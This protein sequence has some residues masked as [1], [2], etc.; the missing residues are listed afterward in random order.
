MHSEKFLLSSDAP[1]MQAP[2]RMGA[3]ESTSQVAIQNAKRRRVTTW[4]AISTVLAIAVGIAVYSNRQ[5][6]TERKISASYLA[7]EQVKS[8]ELEKFQEAMKKEGASPDLLPDHTESTQKFKEFALKNM[9]AALGWQAAFQAASEYL[10]K[11]QPDQAKE[12]LEPLV[13]Q[14]LDNNMLQAKIRRTLVGIYTDEGKFDLA[15][16]ELDFIEKL[17][18][19]PMLQDL[20]LL[21]GKVLYLSGNKAEATKILK[22]LSLAGSADPTT[23]TTATEASMWLGYWGL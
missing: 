17:P 19:T 20:K 15:L 11:R 3:M 8:S 10:A 5:K 4:L 7:I 18:D 21:R 1:S 14:T 22:E 2:S 16:K 6:A 23:S 13:K 9:T 12:L